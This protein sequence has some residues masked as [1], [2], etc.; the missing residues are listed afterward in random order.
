MS[1]CALLLLSNVWDYAGV[2]SFGKG[3]MDDLNDHPTVKPIAL[4]ADAIRDVTH[5][6]EIVLDAFMGSGT[7]ILAA[8]RTKRR[9]FGI[10]I[11]P[12]YVDV[13]VRRWQAMTGED[14][15]LSSSGQSF[16]AVADERQAAEA[17]S[18]TPAL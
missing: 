13:A 17:P 15:V 9:G 12:G 11:E 14:A 3:R 16:A 18:E 8:E 6:G 7:T 1:A 10:E 2:N 4:V 5:P